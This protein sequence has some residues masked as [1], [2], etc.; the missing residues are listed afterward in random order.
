MFAQLHKNENNKNFIML[1]IG[2]STAY[3]D[4]LEIIT[5]TICE[6]IARRVALSEF[7][8]VGQFWRTYNNKVK[9]ELFSFV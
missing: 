4:Q 7:F 9:H 2:L 5:S 1:T 6:K 3:Y 8:A